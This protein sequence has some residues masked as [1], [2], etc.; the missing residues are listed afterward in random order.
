MLVMKNILSLLTTAVLAISLVH[1]QS[2]SGF[3]YMPELGTYNRVDGFRFGLTVSNEIFS[4][5]EAS[6]TYTYAAVGNHYGAFAVNYKANRHWQFTLGWRNESIAIEP[7]LAGRFTTTMGA[8]LFGEDY[9]DYYQL[10]AVTLTSTYQLS[11]RN[12]LRLQLSA[13]DHRPQAVKSNYS[14]L[15]DNFSYRPNP[16]IVADQFAR[17]QAAFIRDTRNHVLR[18]TR[19][20]YLQPRLTWL[21]GEANSIFSYQARVDFS[22]YQ[23]LHAEQ[24]LIIDVGAAYIDKGTPYEEL[25]SFSGFRQLPGI[26]IREFIVDRAIHA[27]IQYALDGMLIGLLGNWFATNLEFVPAYNVAYGELVEN[28]VAGQS[29]M[30][31]PVSTVSLKLQDKFGLINFVAARRLD[32]DDFVRFY[33]SVEL[34]DLFFGEQ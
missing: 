3:S 4:A 9:N 7:A 16:E 17:L 30:D 12:E 32:K 34:F 25:Y 23:R 26:E 6:A 33:L 18:P 19:G 8:L 22:W 21:Y 27:N 2:G 28:S 31:A 15:R 11:R 29:G 1:G 14:F 13:E 10:R 20:Y 24:R 5:V